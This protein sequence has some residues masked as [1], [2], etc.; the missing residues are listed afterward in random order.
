[1]IRTV[2]FLRAV[3][4]GGHAVV[5]MSE[6]KRAFV[7]AGCRHVQTYIQSGNVIFDAP[8]GSPADLFKKIACE[9]DALLGAGALALFRRLSELGNLVQADPFKEFPAGPD[10]KR[11]VAFLSEPPR[12]L[13][14]L[15]LRSQKDELEAIALK[16]LEVL[17]VS[18]KING[19][20]GFPN[21]FVEKEFGIPATSRNWS[22]IDKIVR[23]F[24]HVAP[25]P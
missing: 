12:R 4:V 21:P 15:P 10:V 5:G 22:T 1:M 14:Q 2:A 6:L 11:Y 19:R 16:G 23:L 17:I 24:S 7:A 9:L 3:N 18:R 8:G 25:E 13:P 20:F